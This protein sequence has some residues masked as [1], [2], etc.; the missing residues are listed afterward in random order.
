MRQGLTGLNGEGW[1]VRDIRGRI[2]LSVRFEDGQRTS[3]GMALPWAGTSQADLLLKAA[4]LE[5]LMLK[6]GLGLREAYGLLQGAWGAETQAGELN[7]QEVV[8]RVQCSP[9]PSSAGCSW[10]ASWRPTAVSSVVVGA[11]CGCRT[12]PS[13]CA[14]P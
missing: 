13:S 4:K 6:Q 10:S 9:I 11:S 1:T 8:R 5:M 14:S 7:W 2:Q 3:L 12:P